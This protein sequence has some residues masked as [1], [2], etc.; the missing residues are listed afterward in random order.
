MKSP[1]QPKRVI[2]AND[3]LDLIKHTEKSNSNISETKV[4]TSYSNFSLHSLSSV[5]TTLESKES[6]APNLCAFADEIA[7]KQR[8]LIDELENKKQIL[9]MKMEELKLKKQESFLLQEECK[10][11]KRKTFL[12]LEE[13]NS[14]RK[15]ISS[16]RDEILSLLAEESRLQQSI[17]QAKP[18]KLEKLRQKCLID[19]RKHQEKIL[20]SDLNSEI[21][22]NIA[23]IKSKNLKYREEIEKI[24]STSNCSR[25]SHVLK[26]IVDMKNQKA[27][28]IDMLERKKQAVSVEDDKLRNSQVLLKNNT[29][30]ITAQKLRLRSRIA[31]KRRRLQQFEEEAATLQL[32]IDELL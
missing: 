30:R 18:I 22:F 3:N 9:E 25:K 23:K 1:P 29:K 14:Y 6:E 11:I 31:E 32:K 12:A 19:M 10:S 8:Q 21:N 4:M 26:E 2:S 13:A 17:E 15:Q 24:L 27:K 20:N 7:F 28:L 16:L 5:P